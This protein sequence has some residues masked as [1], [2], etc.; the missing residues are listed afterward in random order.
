MILSDIK[1]IQSEDKL[2]NHRDSFR[3]FINSRSY[4][5]FD[6]GD[7]DRDAITNITDFEVRRKFLKGKFIEN[8][9]GMLPYGHDVPFE[10]VGTEQ[11]EGYKVDK[12]IFQSRPNVYVTA[13]VYIPDGYKQ[14]SGAV[15][16][17]CGHYRDA[18]HANEYHTVCEI[19]AKSGLIVLSQ[20]PV[21]Q[22]ERESYYEEKVND[23]LVNWGTYEH[24]Y[25]GMQCYAVGDGIAKYFLNDLMRGIDFLCQQYPVDPEKIG[26]TGNSGGGTQTALL[27]ICDDRIKAAAPA[28]FIMNRRAFMMEVTDAQDAEQIWPEMTKLGFDHEDILLAM[29]PKPVLVLGVKYD[30]FPIEGA[31]DSVSRCKRIW[32]LYGTDKEQFIELFEDYS[33]HG[34]TFAMAGE[35][36]IFFN[37]HLNN[38]DIS[39]EQ[40]S[41]KKAVDSER[42]ICTESGCLLKEEKYRDAKIVFDE[43]LERLHFFQ[44]EILENMDAEARARKWLSE[45][46]IGCRDVWKLNPRFKKPVYYIDK[47]IANVIWRTQKLLWANSIM[48][49]RIEDKDKRL[50]ITICFW[51][52][53]T[54]NIEENITSIEAILNAGRAALVVDL[55]ADGVNLPPEVKSGSAFSNVYDLEGSIWRGGMDLFWLGDSLAAI[56]VYDVIKAIDFAIEELMI[57]A[58]DIKLFAKDRYCSY[59]LMATLID[60]RINDF[61]FVNCPESLSEDFVGKK[62]YRPDNITSMIIPGMLKYFDLPQLSNWI[63]KG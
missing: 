62:Y 18:K 34:Y 61:D 58:S 53:G 22:G 11:F 25:A 46:V 29:A 42:L 45:R 10:N 57:D 13:N 54:L 20:D 24:T 2:Y 19:I 15:I 41:A 39:E 3:S 12:I 14:N 50:P 56:R 32:R 8:M 30:F 55:T 44:K 43:N 59:V 38:I 4:E 21:G 16:F 36:A 60:S 17:S 7:A 31:R 63:K 28:T 37:K 23:N 40:C 1:K 49:N 51:N 5:A 33:R 26:A 47:M 35:S 27:M 6:K 9:G 52:M 48:I